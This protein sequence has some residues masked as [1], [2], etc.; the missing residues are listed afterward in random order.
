MPGPRL[1]SAFQGTPYEFPNT[2]GVVSRC[3]HTPAC[4][5]AINTYY[6]RGDI[7]IGVYKGT[8]LAEMASPYAEE[9]PL[10]RQRR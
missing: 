9:A 7:P 5:D 10:T 1:V 3:P 4:L 8:A 2:T 6:G